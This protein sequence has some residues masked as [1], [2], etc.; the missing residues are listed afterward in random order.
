M[1][2]PGYQNSDSASSSKFH[3]LALLFAILY[4]IIG[5]ALTCGL[6]RLFKLWMV[7]VGINLQIRLKSQWWEDI[8]FPLE[9]STQS[10]QTIEL[11]VNT[12]HHENSSSLSLQKPF[13]LSKLNY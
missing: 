11:F 13:A 4:M 12:L 9:L 1:I 10:T 3:H 6:L 7:F 2:L 8:N 5:L